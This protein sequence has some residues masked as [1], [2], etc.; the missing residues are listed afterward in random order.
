METKINNK[1]MEMTKKFVKEVPMTV[2][3][4]LKSF[5]TTPCIVVHTRNIINSVKIQET[6]DLNMNILKG[7]QYFQELCLKPWFPHMALVKAKG[8]SYVQ[9]LYMEAEGMNWLWSNA[10]QHIEEL[11]VLDRVD[12]QK[13]EIENYCVELQERLYRLRQLAK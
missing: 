7:I 6:L 9:E 8:T 2:E 11:S 12:I 13:H 1:E 3:E 10:A 4:V 5:K